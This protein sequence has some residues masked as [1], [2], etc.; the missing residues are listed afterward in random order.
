MGRHIRLYNRVLG[1]ELFGGSRN[2]RKITSPAKNV[3]FDMCV[4]DTQE[5]IGLHNFFVVCDT[6]LRC[7]VGV[8]HKTKSLVSLAGKGKVINHKPTPEVEIDKSIN[9]KSHDR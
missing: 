2:G 9:H 1:P 6:R 5:E 7:L 3:I 8:I 4:P